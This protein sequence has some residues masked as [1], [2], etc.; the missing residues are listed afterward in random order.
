[1]ER[2]LRSWCAI[3]VAALISLAGAAQSEVVK[4]GLLR[5]G[6]MT[7]PVYIA[8][9]E[10]YFA[11]QGIDC[12]IVPFDAALPTAVGVVSGDLDIATTGLT[13]GFY[14][15][16]SQGALR[17]IAGY[18]SEAPSFHAQALVASKGAYAAGLTGPAKLGGHTVALTQI[19]GSSQYSLGL[20]AAKYGVDLKTVRVLPLQSNPNAASAVIG[21][22][23]DAAIV[24]GRNILAALNRGDIKLLAWIGDEVPW[25]LGAVITSAR[26]LRDEPGAISR[27]LKAYRQGVRDYH[28]AFTGPNEKRLD[29]PAA[30]KMLGIMAKY[31]GNSVASLENSIG[32]IDRDA[33]LDVA[34][35]RRQIA[36]YQAQSLLSGTVSADAMLSPNLGPPPP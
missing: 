33:R 22:T 13:A 1:V 8:K 9:D 27:F 6:A 29:G 25:Q 7:G 21:G 14:K 2:S 5:E 3:V 30:P 32:Y 35:V 31:T 11:A 10:G 16:A 36:W 15:L 23:A 12:E 24:P 28:D 4:V 19:G 18:G 34:D 17:I 26:K 20:L